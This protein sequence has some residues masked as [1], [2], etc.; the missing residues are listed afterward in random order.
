MSDTEFR[1]IPRPVIVVI[2]QMADITNYRF[3]LTKVA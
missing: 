1:D 3:G 2:K